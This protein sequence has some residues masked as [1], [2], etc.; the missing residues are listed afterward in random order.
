MNP[1]QSPMFLFT[2]AYFDP[3]NYDAKSEC[4]CRN[5]WRMLHFSLDI[6]PSYNALSGGADILGSNENDDD[7]DDETT[8]S[9]TDKRY[10]CYM[11]ATAKGSISMDYSNRSNF[12]KGF[13]KTN[14]GFK[15]Y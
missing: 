4:K 15:I 8:S 6:T 14:N 10:I 3:Y 7:D 12:D 9:L 13:I 11:S 2:I 1:L 5:Y